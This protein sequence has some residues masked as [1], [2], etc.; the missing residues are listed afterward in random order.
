MTKPDPLCINCNLE[1]VHWQMMCD[2][3]FVAAGVP[4]KEV[5]SERVKLPYEI[6]DGQDGQCCK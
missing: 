2:S 1:W 5:V 4:V 6:K 3:V